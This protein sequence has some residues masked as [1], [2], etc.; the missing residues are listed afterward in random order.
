M[1]ERE[2]Q[3]LEYIIEH[4]GVNL[5]SLLEKFSISKRTLYYDIESINYHIRSCGQI[6]NIDRSFC[7]VGNYHSLKEILSHVG[8]RFNVLENRK[9][10]ILYQIL[11]QNWKLS[12]DKFADEM[13]VSRNTV[14]QSMDEIKQ[15]L[16][17]M[18]LSL[19]T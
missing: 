6:K 8:Y 13:L 3:L 15:D 16:I 14:V 12:I 17:K 18:K 19:K 4:N 9:Q 5:D 2:N 1:K 11:N 7:Y 10:Y